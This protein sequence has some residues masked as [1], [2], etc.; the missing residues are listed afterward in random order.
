MI[1]AIAFLNIRHINI[2][3]CK[4]IVSC[5]MAYDKN[6]N[7]SH[8]FVSW[9]LRMNINTKQR[10]NTKI[11][12]VESNEIRPRNNP[13]MIEM[14]EYVQQHHISLDERL[15]SQSFINQNKFKQKK[16]KN[17]E[18]L[19]TDDITDTFNMMYDI[20]REDT[21]KNCTQPNWFTHTSRWTLSQQTWI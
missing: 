20:R 3:I 18:H 7:R 12:N 6:K 5:Q 21:I 2:Y 9:H 1:E 13:R 15:M 8:L 19:A 4:W 16:K 10:R 14:L 11:T 17:N